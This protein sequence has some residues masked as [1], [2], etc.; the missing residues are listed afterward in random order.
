MAHFEESRGSFTITTDPEKQDAEAIYRY[1]SGAY[2]ARNRPREM[3]E[4]SLK[5]SLCFGLFDAGKQIGLAR[6]ISDFA[7]FAYLCDVYVLDSYQGKGL[8]T[9]LMQAV[10]SHPDLQNLRR[11]MLATRDAHALYR[12]SGFTELVSPERW[13]EL[14]TPHPAPREVQ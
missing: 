5:S 9:W 10:M 14:F 2:W 11:W 7:T 3:V 13:M 8:G 12:K 4:R 1:L 6:V